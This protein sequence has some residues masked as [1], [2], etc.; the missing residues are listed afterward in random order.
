MR[1][2]L[3]AHTQALTATGGERFRALSDLRGLTPLEPDAA[4]VFAELGRTT[5]SASGFS[6]RVVLASSATVLMQQRR[7]SE[8]GLGDVFTTD[9]AV[10]LEHLARPLD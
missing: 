4:T 1:A 3:R 9:E 6:G 8:A 2:L 7:M 10:A 5:A